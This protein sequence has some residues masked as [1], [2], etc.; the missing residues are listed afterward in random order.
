MP[1]AVAAAG[2]DLNAAKALSNLGA[3]A[4]PARARTALALVFRAD[5]C[6][7]GRRRP[8]PHTAT[9]PGQR[10]HAGVGVGLAAFRLQ[11]APL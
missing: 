11:A 7:A 5:S 1:D 3:P 8:T 2:D 6:L 10:G 4:I 9:A